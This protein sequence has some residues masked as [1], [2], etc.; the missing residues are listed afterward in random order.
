MQ[1]FAGNASPNRYGDNEKLKIKTE[2]GSGTDAKQRAI[3]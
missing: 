1:L 2:I 3:I